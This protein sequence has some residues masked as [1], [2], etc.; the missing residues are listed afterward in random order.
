MAREVTHLVHGEKG[1]KAAERITH[2]LFN[3]RVDQLT[4][5]DLAQIQLD[6]LPSSSLS[7]INLAETTLTKLIVDTGLATS[8][9]QIKN[10]LQNNS[11]FVNGTA[12]GVKDNMHTADIFTRSNSYYGRYFLLQLGKRKHHLFIL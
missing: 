12:Q 4:K 2:A 8:G 10:A 7:G 11:V 5:H 6:G 1:L 9:K 3:N